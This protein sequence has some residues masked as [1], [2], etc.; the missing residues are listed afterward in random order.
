MHCNIDHAFV[1]IARQRCCIMKF[2]HNSDAWWYFQTFLSQENECYSLNHLN[3]N[4]FL[5]K[6]YDEM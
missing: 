1:L 3:Y 6:A 4:T 2:V 5:K